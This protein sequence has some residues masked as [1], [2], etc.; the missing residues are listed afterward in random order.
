MQSSKIKK[1]VES[2][3]N[4][5]NYEFNI[6]TLIKILLKIFIINIKYINIIKNLIL[7]M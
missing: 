4:V 1:H 3:L 7:I 5:M 2:L 6:M